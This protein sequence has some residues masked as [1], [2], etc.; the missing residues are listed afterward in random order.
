MITRK[1]LKKIERWNWRSARKLMEYVKS[2]WWAPEF[3]WDEQS[4]E[5]GRGLVYSLST[6]GWSE[7]EDLIE[8]MR[9]NL[10]FWGICWLESR[11]GGHYKFLLPDYLESEDAEKKTVAGL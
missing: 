1:Q 6:G 10:V 7:N 5:D 2:L 8:A 11:R 4:S 9:T 3:G